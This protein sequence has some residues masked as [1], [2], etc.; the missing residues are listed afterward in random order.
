MVTAIPPSELLKQGRARSPIGLLRSHGCPT[1]GTLIPGGSAAL[2]AMVPTVAIRY[3]RR[4][5]LRLRWNLTTI[6]ARTLHETTILIS[7]TL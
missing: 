3:V 4:D 5:A 1:T 7:E 6:H 2:M